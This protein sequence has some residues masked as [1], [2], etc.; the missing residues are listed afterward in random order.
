MADGLF[1]TFVVTRVL[2]LQPSQRPAYGTFRLWVAP[3][4][5]HLAP[6]RGEAPVLNNQENADDC[7][8]YRFADHWGA[9]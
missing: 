3:A 7:K 8:R 6:H 5:T 9:L 2:G 4:T 1:R